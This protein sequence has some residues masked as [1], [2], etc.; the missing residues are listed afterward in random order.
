MSI[1][2]HDE[3]IVER[4]TSLSEQGHLPWEPFYGAVD[5]NDEGFKE[6]TQPEG[7][8]LID[9]Q[10]GFGV[11]SLRRNDP[12]HEIIKDPR[13]FVGGDPLQVGTADA[14]RLVKV[15]REHISEVRAGDE[16]TQQKK[17][18]AQIKDAREPLKKQVKG[19]KKRLRQEQQRANSL[20]ES[21]NNLSSDNYIPLT[22][23]TFRQTLLNYAKGTEWANDEEKFENAF[24]PHRAQQAIKDTHRDNFEDK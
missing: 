24:D 4:L 18:E 10:H 1:D 19:L 15:V 11:V 17:M 6:M 5:P 22:V 2:S 9:N 21:I 12:T 20:I 16:P 14:S 7:Y 3:E 8:V 13:V 23:Q